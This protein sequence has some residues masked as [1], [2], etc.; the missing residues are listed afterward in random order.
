MPRPGGG[1]TV[2]DAAGNVWR[3]GATGFLLTTATAFQKT[4]GFGVCGTQ[5]VSPFQPPST[6]SCNHAYLSKQDAAGNILYATYLAGSSQDA[7]TALTTD[8]QGNVYVAGYTYSADFP[9]SSGV[10]QSKYAGPATLS[11]Y[12]SLGAPYG[13]AYVAAGGDAFLAK[14]APDGTLVFCTFLGGA[15]PISPR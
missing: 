3:T 10:V 6:L 2:I 5:N 7:G 8:A 1:T 11:V 15:A 9:V 13:P 14:F 12:T 4:A